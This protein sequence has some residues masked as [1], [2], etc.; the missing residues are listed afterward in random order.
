MPQVGYGAMGADIE[1]KGCDD[2]LLGA[3]ADERTDLLHGTSELPLSVGTLMW[4]NVFAFPY[5]LMLAT[6][7]LVTLPVEAQR[8]YPDDKGV[9]LGVMLGVAG[10]SQLVCP[11]AG[12]LSDRCGSRLGRRV[13][14]M[15]GGC[16][17]LV[18]GIWGMLFARSGDRPSPG[19]YMGSLFVAL[20]GIN[21]V[22]SAFSALNADFVPRKQ[23]GLASGIL[24]I[25]QLTGSCCGFLLFMFVIDVQTAYPVYACAAVVGVAGSATAARWMERQRGDTLVAGGTITCSGIR[26]CYIITPSTHGDFFWVFVIRIFYYLALSNQAFLLYYLNDGIHA[27]DP[28]QALTEIITLTQF[29]GAIVTV[30]LGLLSDK[31]GRKRVLVWMCAI[32]SVTYVV[33]MRFPPLWV[34]MIACCVYGCANSGLVTIE[35]ALA[36]DTLPDKSATARDLGIWGVAAFIGAALGPMVMGPLL[37]F[38]GHQDGQEGYA[39]RGYTAIFI[40]AVAFVLTAAGL[41]RFVKGST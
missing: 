37:H 20:L 36:C 14:F 7:G 1:G 23:M 24:A 27:P 12:Y 25:M 39:R 21:T 15:G 6:M 17:A 10:L 35:Y 8:M 26:E 2:T 9:M 18:L 32:Q 13:P 11:V 28:Q 19:L 16:V 41:I 40:C 22:Y 5:S 4:L 29:I 3:A 34:V 33:F 30:P 38:V 31:L